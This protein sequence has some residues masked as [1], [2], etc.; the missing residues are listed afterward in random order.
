MSKRP[1]TD[2]EKIFQAFSFAEINRVISERQG[3]SLPPLERMKRKYEAGHELA[4]I[5][6]LNECRKKKTEIPDWIFEAL[7]R[8]FREH[9]NGE[10]KHQKRGRP[11]SLE[12]RTDDRR[13]RLVFTALRNRGLAAKAAV[14]EAAKLFN[15]PERTVRRMIQR[16]K[17]PGYL[18]P[19]QWP[20]YYF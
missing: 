19:L 9:A 20:G 16:A 2:P 3:P 10:A 13:V 6:A 5:D 12:T 15:L 18:S 14:C 11:I 8:H 7:N 4:A 1:R 17:K